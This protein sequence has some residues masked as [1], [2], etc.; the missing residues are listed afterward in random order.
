MDGNILFVSSTSTIWIINILN[1]LQFWKKKERRREYFWDWV[2]PKLD[3][4]N[5]KKNWKIE[6]F[7]SSNC[8]RWKTYNEMWNDT[9]WKINFYVTEKKNSSLKRLNTFSIRSYS[10]IKNVHTIVCHSLMCVKCVFNFNSKEHEFMAKWLR[11]FIQISILRIITNRINFRYVCFSS[12][13][14]FDAEQK[15]MENIKSN[16]VWDL[17]GWYRD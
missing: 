16:G 7:S 6:Y 8:H 17:F 2:H 12:S 3:F 13:N 4:N 11:L 5:L 14:E 15:A 10:N 1:V 9:K